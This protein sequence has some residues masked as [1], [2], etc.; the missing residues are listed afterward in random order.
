MLK[1]DLPHISSSPRV[2]WTRVELQLFLAIIILIRWLALNST[3]TSPSSTTSVSPHLLKY[4]TIA[5]DMLDFLSI[6]QDPV[7]GLNTQ[8]VYWTLAAWS[9]STI[10]FFVRIPSP[11]TARPTT[12]NKTAN[13][14][15]AYLT[16]SL[17]SVFLLDLPYF[18]IRIAAIFAFG[19]HGLNS[20]FFAAKNLVLI[21]F[22]LYK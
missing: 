18:G 21:G 11:S 2:I 3:L 1:P 5:C 14:L 19:S 16:N 15:R 4:L 13:E 6:T 8:L 7:L 9:W 22:Q 12:F 20:Y 17:L 10:Q